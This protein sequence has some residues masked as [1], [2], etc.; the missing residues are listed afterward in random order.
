MRGQARTNPRLKIP[1]FL[2]SICQWMLRHGVCETDKLVQA[3]IPKDV[4]K[5]AADVDT[6]RDVFG[7]ESDLA[8]IVG[9][10]KFWL[11]ELPN[12]L[13]VVEVFPNLAGAKDAEAFVGIVEGMPQVH[14]DALGFVVGFLKAVV[15]AEA[16]TKAS[17]AA[18]AGAF[19]PLCVRTEHGAAKKDAAE[20][21]TKV[22]LQLINAWGTREFYPIDE[23]TVN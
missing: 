2:Y 5:C 22:L 10:F 19:G 17:A 1:I 15:A 8:K 6:G 9:L 20:T 21:G 18:V 13:V 23:A 16:R 3:P 7:E 14:V 4:E 12:P 11:A